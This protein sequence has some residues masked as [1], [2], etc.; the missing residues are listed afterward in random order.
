[1]TNQ[2][3]IYVNECR[4]TAAR[5]ALDDSMKEYVNALQERG[6]SNE[7]LVSDVCDILAWATDQN[8]R[9]N[10]KAPLLE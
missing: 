9:I 3:E 4:V 5:Q 8:V 6:L 2:H 7:R 1:M 10:P